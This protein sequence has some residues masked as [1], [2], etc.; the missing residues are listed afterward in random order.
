VP[1]RLP[2]KL[3]PVETAAAPE[4]PVAKSA[5]VG[6]QNSGQPKVL[7]AWRCTDPLPI[8]TGSV[9]PIGQ[10]IKKDAEHSERCR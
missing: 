1:A 2:A 6:Q 5:A 4:L 8:T 7:S 3:P 9:D 10:V